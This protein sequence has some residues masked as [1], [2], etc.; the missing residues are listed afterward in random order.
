[1]T[2]ST[3]I[4]C[5]I[6]GLTL[7]GLIVAGSVGTY[8]LVRFQQGTQLAEDGYTA[9]LTGDFDGA[10]A[11]LSAALQTPISS[12]QRS[13][14]YLNRGFAYNNR[15]RFDDAI[16]DFNAALQLNPD[17]PEA[18]ADRGNAYQRKGET[19]K[20]II[21]FNKA[22]ELDPNSTV[23]YFNRGLIFL[24]KSEWDK[25]LADFD[26]AVR[27]DPASADALVN[28]G[29]CYVNKK[30]YQHALANFDGAI[31]IDSR[32][33][34]AFQ[35]RGDLYRRLGD[36]EKSTRD[37][38]Q[39]AQLNPPPRKQVSAAARTTPVLP[40]L[41]NPSSPRRLPPL[42]AGATF[43]ANIKGLS[44]VGPTQENLALSAQLAARAGN[45]DRTIDFCNDALRKNMKPDRAAALVMMRANAYSKKADFERALHDY[46]EATTLN[47]NLVRGYIARAIVFAHKKDFASASNE[48]DAI[49][50]RNPRALADVL[51]SIA[52]IRA[53]YPEEGLRDGK[54]A[55]ESAQKAC[56]LSKWRYW[57]YIDTL[58]AA[59]A[60]TGDFDQAV[61]YEER[62]LQAAPVESDLL[63]GV[64]QRLALYK[65]H[66]P[67]RETPP[68]G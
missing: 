10:I 51:N 63:P 41:F 13:Y 26:E 28:R 59:A 17:I 37:L 54:K 47:P 43:D 57:R 56:E 61:K 42:S 21:D 33:V 2:K 18:Y 20:A 34:R 4:A 68:E 8:W 64:K 6:G 49:A 32:N 50:P 40:P 60:E 29:I 12:Y 48:L 38:D 35:N 58:A 9:C 5:V 22:I 55:V 62:A 27:C 19:D 36:R 14:V 45:W 16:R 1:V 24:N 31:S 65:E 15:W 39:V 23:A 52:W 67:Y 44:N 66:K 7:L 53:T 25:A 30:D 11:K 3:K 46:A